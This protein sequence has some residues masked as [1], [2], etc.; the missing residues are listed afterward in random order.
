MKYL[1]TCVLFRKRGVRLW[2]AV[3]NVQNIV[4]LGYSPVAGHSVH[5][6]TSRS[7]TEVTLFRSNSR[8]QAEES[9]LNEY[10]AEEKGKEEMESKNRSRSMSVQVNPC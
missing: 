9:L 3:W 2:Q 4:G 8:S 5:A 10:N 7:N 6:T 1:S